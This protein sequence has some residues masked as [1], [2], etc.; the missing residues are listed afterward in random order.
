VVPPVPGHGPC[1]LVV[2]CPSSVL[3]CRGAVVV[4]LVHRLAVSTTFSEHTTF[5]EKKTHENASKK[6]RKART[7]QQSMEKWSRKT[8]KQGKKKKAI[9]RQEFYK[10][11]LSEHTLWRW[12]PARCHHLLTRY[13]QATHWAAQP[14]RRLRDVHIGWRHGNATACGLG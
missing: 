10:K 7:K 5:T 2:A 14:L 12:S 13:T 6:N 11:A 9:Q 1:P 3:P 4:L 8:I